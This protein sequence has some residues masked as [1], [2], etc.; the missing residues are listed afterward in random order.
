[1]KINNKHDYGYGFEA[2]RL[3]ICRNSNYL[4]DR[5]IKQVDINSELKN[6]QFIRKLYA[7]LIPLLP[8]S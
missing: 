2:I 1:M 8:K 4:G 3:W 6:G 7:E 5:E